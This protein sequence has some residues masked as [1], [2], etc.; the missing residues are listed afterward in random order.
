MNDFEI[1]KSA[2]VQNF[3]QC[4]DKNLNLNQEKKVIFSA[5][6]SLS[7]LDFGHLDINGFFFFF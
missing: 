1:L 2:E 3:N 7:S 4:Y 5:R 6:S